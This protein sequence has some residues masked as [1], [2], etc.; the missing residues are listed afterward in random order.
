VTAAGHLD[1]LANN[2]N[3]GV[4][5]FQAGIIYMTQDLGAAGGATN[6]AIKDEGIGVKAFTVNTT[7]GLRQDSDLTKDE[8]LDT[9]KT[10][11]YDIEGSKEISGGTDPR[12]G[13]PNGAPHVDEL[14]FLDFTV[15]SGTWAANNFQ[16][17]L[18]KFE[19]DNKY[20]LHIEYVG[21]TYHATFLGTGSG[22]YDSTN[23]VLRV[24][25]NTLGL[26]NAQ[27]KS[28]YV[29]AVDDNPAAPKST[30]EHFLLNGFTVNTPP[31]NPI[32][33]PASLVLLGSGLVLGANRLRRRK[34]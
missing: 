11:D 8:N 22:V 20:F 14:A 26:P 31:D 25:S 30:A 9:N 27:L 17:A 34:G 6:A 19:S 16:F 18:T 13:F 24:N 2:A 10:N 33:E 7:T 4:G 28:F 23:E 29:R 21:G 3:V 32:P 12:T 15:G 1:N 5:D